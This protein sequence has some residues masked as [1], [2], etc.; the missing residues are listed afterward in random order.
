M[1]TA[2]K[3]LIILSVSDTDSG[4]WQ[5]KYE[6]NDISLTLC[7]YNVTVEVQRCSAPNHTSD[8]QKIYADW[9]HEFQK[10]K[11]A[12]DEWQLKQEVM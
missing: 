12:M 10:Y 2:Q 6:E 8:F 11:L 3:G 1:Q 5:L 4:Q 7:T 9:C